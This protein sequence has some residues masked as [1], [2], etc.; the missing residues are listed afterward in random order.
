M[1]VHEALALLKRQESLARADRAR[2]V[3]Q[4]RATQTGIFR[5]GYAALRDRIGFDR[6]ILATGAEGRRAAA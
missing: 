5:R 3:E 1:Q 4:A 2:L 6:P